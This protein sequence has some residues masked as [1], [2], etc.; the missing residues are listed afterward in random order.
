MIVATGLHI[1]AQHC[2]YLCML[3]VQPG[4]CVLLVNECVSA[5]S[6]QACTLSTCMHAVMKKR[7]QPH[8]VRRGLAERVLDSLRT[9]LTQVMRGRRHHHFQEL[10]GCTR[11]ELMVGVTVAAVS[12]GVMSCLQIKQQNTR[13]NMCFSQLG[14]LKQY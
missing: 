9:R 3:E 2:K 4:L 14:G 8:T 5:V 6:S 1:K 7:V 13:D 11:K 12:L 10:L